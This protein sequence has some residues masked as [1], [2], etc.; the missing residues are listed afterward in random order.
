MRISS[1]LAAI[2]LLV[3]LTQFFT[4]SSTAQV[5][6]TITVIC[7]FS[8]SLAPASSY[9]R[10]PLLE[11]NYTISSTSACNL[12]QMSGLFQVT[13]LTSNALVYQ[14]YTSLSGGNQVVKGN[15][16][17]STSNMVNATYSAFLTVSIEGFST[18]SSNTFSLLNYANVL[19]TGFT[20][21]QTVNQGQAVPLQVTMKNVGQAASSPITLSLSL[22]GPQTSDYG[23]SF[24]AL[25]PGQSSNTTITLNGAT[26]VTGSYNASIFASYN[27]LG[28]SANSPIASTTFSVVTPHQNIP[29]GGGG[30]G[31][32]A[33]G[34]VASLPQVTFTYLP[35]GVSGQPGEVQQSQLGFKNIG[36]TPETLDLSVPSQYSSIISL[37]TMNLILNPNQSATVPVFF[38]PNLSLAT[39]VYT[40]PVLIRANYQG[41]KEANGTQYLTFSVYRQ[42]ATQPT[43]ATQVYL[44]N[45]TNTASG[46]ISIISSRGQGVVN[47]TLV[48][49]L[50]GSIAPN[51][52]DLDFYGLPTNITEVNGTYKIVSYIGNLPRNQTLY[53][54]YSIRSAQNPQLL[55]RSQY[56]IYTLSA[57]SSQQ[58]LK[59]ADISAPTISSN[60]TG[61]I[62][63]SLLYTGT[64]QKIVSFYMIA[65]PQITLENSTQNVTAL[66]NE[67]IVRQ[68][69]I[70][71]HP[72]N[73]T[74]IFQLYIK[75]L[76]AN[77]SYGIPVLINPPNVAA[78]QSAGVVPFYAR[79]AIF[80]VLIIALLLLLRGRIQIGRQRYSPT[81]AGH[82]VRIREQIKRDAE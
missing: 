22:V 15:I 52:S 10:L 59:V 54:Y 5:N 70:L 55:L 51:V 53:E 31:G 44:T 48:E 19:I 73:G 78:Q 2:A 64:T 29:S 12:G 8:V 72:D 69:K 63:V 35:I 45:S 36:T 37:S 76:G 79:I 6:A 39:G 60:S 26:N 62:T 75:T 34:Q 77:L 38:K 61:T 46:V 68:F 7:P 50:P 47:G 4:A 43:I 67:L 58:I 11:A 25:S 74:Y 23:Y 3:M 49:W 16:Q 13:N 65:P 40:I 30:S 18:S 24:P 71:K 66:P 14:Q 28:R 56:A 1:T 81:R 20:A 9:A 33:G 41:G 21:P 17:F 57:T 32:G 42:N 80:I 27:S 82:L